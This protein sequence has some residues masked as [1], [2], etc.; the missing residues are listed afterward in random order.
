MVD[1]LLTPSVVI[2][3]IAAIPG[4]LAFVGSLSK[5]GLDERS[6]YYQEVRRDLNRLEA[7]FGLMEEY[8]STLE[9]H[10]DELHAQMIASG[11]RPPARP[12]RPKEWFDGK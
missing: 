6:S 4:V 1:S 7:R 3:L 10:I 9:T 8:V 12:R 11:L 5:A 2:A